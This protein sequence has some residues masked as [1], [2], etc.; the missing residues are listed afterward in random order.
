MAIF[1]LAIH[2]KYGSMVPSP[3]WAVGCINWVHVMLI[4]PTDSNCTFR[5]NI[6][7]IG[8]LSIKLH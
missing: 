8:W 1:G 3:Y 4:V 6:S 7:L 2:A 5:D